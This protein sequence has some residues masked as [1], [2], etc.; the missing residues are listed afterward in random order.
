MVPATKHVMNEL[1]RIRAKHARELSQVSPAERVL[2]IKEEGDAVLAKYG[3]NLIEVD[4][5]GPP[6]PPEAPATLQPDTIV[7]LRAHKAAG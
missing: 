2:R 3:L 5:S 4:R 6:A 7:R 1:H